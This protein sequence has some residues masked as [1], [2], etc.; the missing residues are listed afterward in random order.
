MLSIGR[1][2]SQSAC[3]SRYEPY[4]SCESTRV[5]N[6]CYNSRSFQLLPPALGAQ[7]SRFEELHERYGP[8][9]AKNSVPAPKIASHILFSPS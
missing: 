3:P 6:A 5:C 2:L 7:I 1:A 9:P 4:Y 8:Q